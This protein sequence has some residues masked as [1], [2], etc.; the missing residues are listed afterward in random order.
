[1]PKQHYRLAFD[2]ARQTLIL[3][4]HADRGWPRGL[5]MQMGAANPAACEAFAYNPGY[6]G[7]PGIIHTSWHRLSID[8]LGEH[9]VDGPDSPL[10]CMTDAF[11]Y[12]PDPTQP[13]AYTSQLASLLTQRFRDALTALGYD[14]DQGIH[15][16]RHAPHEIILMTQKPGGTPPTKSG[17]TASQVWL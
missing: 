3:F 17:Y 8:T 5:A 14:M 9:A 1:M 12:P 16:T 13:T 10:W 7:E 4:D 6:G 15:V 11:G 2:A